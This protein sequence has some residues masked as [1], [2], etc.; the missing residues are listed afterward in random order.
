MRKRP[1]K[2][3]LSRE[4]LRHLQSPFL[5]QVRGGESGTCPTDCDPTTGGGTQSCDTGCCGGTAG[6]PQSYTCPPGSYADSGC[7]FCG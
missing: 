7:E 5:R 6:C 4:T 2:L 3:A 1:R